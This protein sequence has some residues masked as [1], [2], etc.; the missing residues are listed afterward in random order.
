MQFTP[1]E[2]MALLLASR[3]LA[4]TTDRKYPVDKQTAYLQQL[5]QAFTNGTQVKLKYKDRFGDVQII[6]FEPYFFEPYPEKRTIYSIGRRLANG[7]KEEKVL[8]LRLDRIIGLIPTTESYII[9]NSFNP[10]QRLKNA[11]TIW[12]G[13]EGDALDIVILHI[14]SALQS[15]LA[16]TIWHHSQQVTNNPDGSILMQ[17]SVSTWREMVK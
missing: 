6:T 14:A 3:M 12:G 1:D 10:I 7:T 8:T 2:C 9:S 17:F 15:Q 11:W 13:D 4:R 16:H 5:T